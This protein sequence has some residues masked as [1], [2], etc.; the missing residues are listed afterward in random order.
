MKRLGWHVQLRYTTENVMLKVRDD[1]GPV[2]DAKFSTRK[3]AKECQR[4]LSKLITASHFEGSTL[5]RETELIL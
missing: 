1:N 4:V 5:V 3:D 2:R